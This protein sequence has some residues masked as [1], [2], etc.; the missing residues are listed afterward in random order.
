MLRHDDERAND[1]PE[2]GSRHRYRR[3]MRGLSLGFLLVLVTASIVG[4]WS[5]R[6]LVHDQEEDLLRARAAEVCLVL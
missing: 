5:V 4:A 2:T 1:R 6:N 3:R